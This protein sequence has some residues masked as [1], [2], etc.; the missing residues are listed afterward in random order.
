MFNAVDAS[1]FNFSQLNSLVVRGHS[2]L[3]AAP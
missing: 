1:S 2:E 3:Y